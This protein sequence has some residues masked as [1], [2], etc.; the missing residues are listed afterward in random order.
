MK[1]LRC[2]EGEKPLFGLCFNLVIN[3][4]PH[5][6]QKVSVI[7]CSTGMHSCSPNAL[8]IGQDFWKISDG[9]QFTIADAMSRAYHLQY[10]ALFTQLNMINNLN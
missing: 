8:N 9:C 3:T 2:N 5:Y 6:I 7:T 10:L 1:L 4:Q